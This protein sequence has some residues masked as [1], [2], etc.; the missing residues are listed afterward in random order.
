VALPSLG[1]GM[2]HNLTEYSE[3]DIESWLVH[4]VKKNDDIEDT[5]HQL[6][7]V[8]KDLENSLFDIKVMQ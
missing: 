3:I 2:L 1:L 4:Y 5:F 6:S 8:F 7:M